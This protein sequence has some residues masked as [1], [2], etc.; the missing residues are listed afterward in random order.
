MT[1]DITTAPSRTRLI[2]VSW[3][4]AAAHPVGG[5]RPAFLHGAALADALAAVP[6]DWQ[7]RTPVPLILLTG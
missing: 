2:P 4:G 7:P 3:D 6:P 5:H 1:G